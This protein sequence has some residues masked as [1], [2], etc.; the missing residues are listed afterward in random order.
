MSENGIQTEVNTNPMVFEELATSLAT[1]AAYARDEMGMPFRDMEFLYDRAL[2]GPPSY[3]EITSLTGH[4]LAGR[5]R[6]TGRAAWLMMNT[7]RLDIYAVHSRIWHKVAGKFSA[8]ILKQLSHILGVESKLSEERVQSLGTE[9]DMIDVLG[10][11]DGAIWLVQVVKCDKVVDSALKRT[12]GSGK[13]FR[14]VVYKDPVV[15]KKQLQALKNSRQQM[16]LAFPDVDVATLVIVQHSTGPDF[17]VYQVDV[18]KRLGEKLTLKPGMIRKNSIDFADKLTD[19]PEALLTMPQLLNN[20]LF[21]GVPPCRGGRTLGLLAS[22]ATRQIGSDD[23]NMFKRGEFIRMMLEDYDFEIEN[24]KVRHDLDDRLVAQGFFRKWGPHYF[25]SMKGIARY[26]YCLAKF[27][28]KGS[29]QFD[30]DLCVSQ[31]DRILSR[32]GCLN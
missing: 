1:L 14:S 8:P 17:E 18:T 9:L 4:S 15:K 28:T 2:Q 16:S 30:L 10:V 20:N 23:L 29:K 24:D 25:V 31:R 3:A 6:Q 11:K 12:H 13:L 21:R 26:Q 5:D 19:N 7:E 32:F 22:A 27:T